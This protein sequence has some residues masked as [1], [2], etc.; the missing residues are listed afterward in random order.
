MQMHGKPPMPEEIEKEQKIKIYKE[1][2]AQERPRDQ[3]LGGYEP[4]P[5]GP[6]PKTS[7]N[8]DTMVTSAPAIPR[9]Q[10]ILV[11]RFRNKLKMRGGKGIVGMRRQ[12]KIMDDNGSGTL[13][14]QEFRKGIKDF[15]VE[16]DPKDVD[17]LFKAFDINNNG[18]ID[19]DE[20][21]R[22]VVGPMN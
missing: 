5:S 4:H 17:N 2:K 9:F 14:L 22:V 1:T 19:Y 10:S 16:M 6:K 12:F 20:F 8:T 3:T 7:V 15:Q 18:D 21:V 13:D 11:E